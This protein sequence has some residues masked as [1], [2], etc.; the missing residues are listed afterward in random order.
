[1][2]LQAIAPE[3]LTKFCSL[4]TLSFLERG[5]Q[6]KMKA[7]PAGYCIAGQLLFFWSVIEDP[8]L[9]EIMSF[10]PVSVVNSVF[11]MNS[12]GRCVAFAA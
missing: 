4:A 11:R 3:L 9:P 5:G 1:M 12:K 8:N 10:S 7:T 2:V 6:E